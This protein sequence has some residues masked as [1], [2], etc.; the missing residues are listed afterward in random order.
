MSVDIAAFALD[1]IPDLTG[2]I[3]SYNVTANAHK[4]Q[5]ALRT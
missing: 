2:I 4:G 1:F 5:K 3:I